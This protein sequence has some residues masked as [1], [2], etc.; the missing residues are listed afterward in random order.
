MI[1]FY[2]HY[3]TFKYKILFFNLIN[4][5]TFFQKFVN[6]LFMNYLN[7]FF[8]IYLN[9]ILIYF[10]NELEHEI[11]IKKI[12]NK[13]HKIELQLDIKKCEFHVTKT[14]YL[15]YIINT[16]KIKINLKKIKIIK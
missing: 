11:H 6:N 13:L 8:F 14:K 16:K 7:I 9:D 10:E 4:D 2:T 5:F 15:N 1:I 12:L 3:E